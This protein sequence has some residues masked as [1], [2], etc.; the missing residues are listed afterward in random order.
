MTK[1]PIEQ[2]R[3]YLS[4]CSRPGN[5]AA[6][7]YLWDVV[8]YVESLERENKRLTEISQTLCSLDGHNAPAFDVIDGVDHC[9]ICGAAV[10]TGE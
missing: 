10:K 7:D 5:H 6:I 1:S 4:S 9:G 8:D 2:A 3:E